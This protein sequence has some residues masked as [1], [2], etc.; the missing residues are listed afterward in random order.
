M[1]SEHIINALK[2]HLLQE[3]AVREAAELA[4]K[5]KMAQL[6]QLQQQVVQLNEQL[7][8]KQANNASELRQ[9]QEDLLTASN[10]LM[11][12]VQNFQY[13]VIM[14]NESGKIFMVNNRLAELFLFPFPVE[15]LMGL[16]CA[17]GAEG[18]KDY[19][20]KPDEFLRCMAK[21]REDRVPVLNEEFRLKNRKIVS[22][23]YIPIWHNGR[24]YGNLWTYTDVAE[25]RAVEQRLEDQKQFYENV[26]NQLPVD[27]IVL[28]AQKE[29]LFVNPHNTS[30]PYLREWVI[31][32]SYTD[33]R[34][35]AQLNDELADVR[36]RYIE[37]SIAE[38]KQFAWEEKSV[39]GNGEIKHSFKRLYPVVDD[40]GEVKQVIGCGLDITERKKIE[41]QIKGSEKRYRDLF[42][43]SQ[44]LICT[45]DMEGRILSVNPALCKSMGYAEKDLVGKIISDFFPVDDQRLFAGNYLHSI[46]ST[47]KADGVL[48]VVNR[49]ASISYLLFQNYKMEEAGADPY[50][51]GFAQDITV[52]VNT[53]RE[54]RKA[55]QVTEEM[56]HAKEV[57]LANMSHE[58]RTPMTAIVGI[59]G[60]MGKT[61]LNERQREYLRHIQASANNLLMIVNDVLDLEKI[62]AGKLKFERVVF[63]VQERVDICVQSFRF[64]AEEKGVALYYRNGLGDDDTVLGDPHRLSQ[65][66][67]NL[68]S[69]AVKFTERGAI[70]VKTCIHEKNAD[71]I[72]I[73]FEVID[74]G[75]GIPENKQGEIFEP[76]VQANSAVSRKYGGTG[77]GLSISRD[78]VQLMN[79]KLNVI[80]QPGSGSAFAF[81]LPF[82]RSSQK[83]NNANMALE[84]NYKSLG[85]KKVL[86]AEDVE[87]NQY[88]AK[89]IME[90]WGF[91]VNIANNG[92]E[93]VRMVEE[94]EYDLVLM[95][96]QMPEMDGMEATRR[97][98]QMGNKVKAA[99]P[100]IALTANAL[101]GD[102]EKYMAAGMNDYLSKPFDEPKLFL[103][104]EKNL[105][106]G[107][108][109]EKAADQQPMEAASTFSLQKLYN[110]STV[111]AISGGDQEFIKRML[112]L[113]LETMPVSLNE[114]KAHMEQQQWD[115]LSKI[116]H[117][118][119]S[120]VDSMGIAAVKEDIR[121]IEWNAKKNENLD[122]L[123]ALVA[124][125]VNIVELCMDQ[126][127]KDF[128]LS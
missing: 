124:K 25:K 36:L 75:I 37:R 128:S 55:K 112:V 68:I 82:E 33:Y 73:R 115:P 72:R 38:K 118:I 28:N 8:L 32:K 116:A 86:V 107:L 81:V 11:L 94:G 91:E 90:S 53:E 105:G 35:R 104:I 109:T 16:T 12:L 26:L 65:V 123:P 18:A 40:K 29:F 63:S 119:K 15:K 6:N 85:R 117:K 17:E 125:V 110:L 59:A 47:G 102:S 67:N 51:I 10:R 20:E 24:F 103:V 4:T 56:A 5:E 46:T 126:L 84:I 69:N 49:D 76:F 60:L 83:P 92:S 74:T 1:S 14:V 95:D 34:R 101:K 87:L 77:L 48:R 96:I 45:H 79:G 61:V 88:L 113:F 127:R 27:I 7:G 99:T 80:S 42:N 70:T 19:F 106:S 43:F 41:E 121:T 54:L 89:H 50:V 122:Q 111:E 52:R 71:S 2:G 66:L 93:A 64:K 62:I 57:F 78:L 13:A 22:R 100:I 120:T 58:I 97:I 3:Q 44:A 9:A 21:M 114:M 30:D 39:G 98:R 31:G 23:D 108:R